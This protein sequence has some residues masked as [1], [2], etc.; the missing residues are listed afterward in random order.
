MRPNHVAA[1]APEEQ[2]LA[3]LR[4]QNERARRG[5]ARR[6]TSTPVDEDLAIAA[7]DRDVTD[8]QFTEMKDRKDVTVYGSAPARSRG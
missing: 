3:D 8:E 7:G 6:Y 1:L 4:A 5:V 2:I